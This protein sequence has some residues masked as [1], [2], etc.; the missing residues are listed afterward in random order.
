[1]TDF[2]KIIMSIDFDSYF[3]YDPLFASNTQVIE[4]CNKQRKHIV[5]LE[6]ELEYLRAQLKS[7]DEELK[8]VRELNAELTDKLSSFKVD[9]TINELKAL[10][11]KYHELLMSQLSRKDKNSDQNKEWKTKYIELL[12]EYQE[13]VQ[14]SKEM[15]EREKYIV[16]EKENWEFTAD[17][18]RADFDKAVSEKDYIASKY[19]ELK[20]INKKQA[21]EIE[22]QNAT[23]AAAANRIR[24]L[25]TQISKYKELEQIYDKLLDSYK[26]IKDNK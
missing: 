17:A 2:E 14:R 8:H 16:E 1:M 3:D 22:K 7:Q 25:E 18:Y 21:E 24:N 6:K 11:Q 15:V 4:Q 23:L 9:N 19:N 13:L 12:K 20:E 5:Y 10:K 26:N